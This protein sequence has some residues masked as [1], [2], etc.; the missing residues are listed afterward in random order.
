[1]AQRLARAGALQRVLIQEGG[2]KA[3]GLGGDVRPRAAGQVELV[4]QDR[5]PAGRGT[6]AGAGR[7]GRSGEGSGG[8][9]RWPAGVSPGPLP[10]PPLAARLSHRRRP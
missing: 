7:S 9:P 2:H 6:K 1:V 8:D 3:A 4:A 5:L 10:L